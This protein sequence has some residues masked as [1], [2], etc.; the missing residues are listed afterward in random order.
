MKIISFVVCVFL[1]LVIMRNRRKI[2]EKYE[3]NRMKKTLY[4]MIIDYEDKLGKNR[5]ELQVFRN[6]RSKGGFRGHMD[7]W[8]EN[9]LEEECRR[10]SNDISEMWSYRDTL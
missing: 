9:Q 6:E 10:L 8:K 4:R 7:Y 5:K 1:L 2:R 3:K